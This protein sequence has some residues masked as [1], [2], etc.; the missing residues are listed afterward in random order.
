MHFKDKVIVIT[1]ASSGIGEQLA[2]DFSR[3]GAVVI[4]LARNIEKLASLQKELPFSFAI[5]CDVGK[6]SSVASA[7][8]AIR[9]LY[10]T[11]DILV[12][13]AG[14]GRHGSFE[15][16]TIHD[17]HMQMET[18]YFGVVYS[19]KNALPLMREGSQIVFV[20]SIVGKLGIPGLAVYSSTKFAV[21]GLAEALRHELGKKRIAVRVVYP[22]GVKTPFFNHP[23]F[24]QYL[25]HLHPGVWTTPSVVSRKILKG[26]R[27]G[28]T[29]IFVPPSLK[30]LLLLRPLFG[31]IA[32]II[33][34]RMYRK[35]EF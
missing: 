12:A 31:P 1:G 27:A 18:N 26:I 8:S 29:E 5:Q 14:I 3:E 35:A 16:Q 2:R 30:Y 13:N 19:L 24:Q 6:E 20:S 34:R 11:I 22:A 4:M 7:F 28:K 17:I 15:S 32:R 21:T 10:G 25:D 23:S 33:E 9:N